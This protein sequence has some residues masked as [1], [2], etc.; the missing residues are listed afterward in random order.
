MTTTPRIAYVLK[1]YPRFS[2]TFILSEILELERQGVDLCIYSL[3]KPDDGRF[4]AALSR[5][6]A[7]VAYLPESPFLAIRSVL[8]AN[9]EVFRWNRRRYLRLLASSIKRRR[10]G[11]VKRF[12]QAGC[13]ASR[14]RAEGITHIHA[15]FATSATS[16]AVWL[17]RLT[18]LPYSFTAHAKDIFS[19][20]VDPQGLMRKLRAA[21][22]VVTVSDFNRAYLRELAGPEHGPRVMR[23]YNGLDL[24]QFSPNGTR[25]DDLP[26][27]LAVGRLVEK[28]G[29]DD[30][31]RACVYLRDA[32]LFFR[33]MIVGKGPE[34]ARLRRLIMDLGVNGQ[35]ELVGPLPREALIELY[36]RASVFAAPCVVGN[37]GNRDGLPTVL[38]EAMALGVPVVATPVTGIPELVDDGRTGILVPE[39]DPA[40]LATAIEK[41]LADPLRA[42]ELAAAGRTR[43][44]EAFDLRAN[45]RLLRALF[46]QE[47]HEPVA[48]AVS[49][50]VMAAEVR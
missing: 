27:I 42:G 7:P 19:D 26:L 24:T 43:I 48:G 9:R 14:L 36:P 49:A 47:R 20:G 2:E 1:M 35:V 31:V 13:L 38:I 33:C 41:L 15:H 21:D 6:R 25:R 12:L 29:F 17:H 16:V 37:D 39:R 18:G 11:A 5:V 4:H 22:F 32:G 45:V 46:S 50:V 40:A 8:A 23:V 34:E 10:W 3:K 44:E 28:K 30:L